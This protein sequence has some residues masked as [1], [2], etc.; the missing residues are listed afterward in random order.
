LHCCKGTNSEQLNASVK[1]IERQGGREEEREKGEG[2]KGEKKV[3]REGE[4]KGRRER[5]R[6]SE[7]ASGRGRN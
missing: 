3:W 5:E 1:V 6:E 4:G 7:E 2:R